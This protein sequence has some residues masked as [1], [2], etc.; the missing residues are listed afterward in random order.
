MDFLELN[1]PY[2]FAIILI[3]IKIGKNFEK[4]AIMGRPWDRNKGTVGCTGTLNHTWASVMSPPPVGDITPGIPKY[5]FIMTNIFIIYQV[6]CCRNIEKQINSNLGQINQSQAGINFA[7]PDYTCY[8]R[9]KP[10]MGQSIA[11]QARIPGGPVLLSPGGPPSHPAPAADRL[12]QI[13][14]HPAGPVRPTGPLRLQPRLGLEPVA[15]AGL[16][17]RPLPGLL[18]RNALAGC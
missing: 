14:S 16:P 18:L 1:L 8:G 17:G 2:F 15:P 4:I 13:L 3:H 9:I 5:P 10:I 11:A 6:M 12:G 7:R